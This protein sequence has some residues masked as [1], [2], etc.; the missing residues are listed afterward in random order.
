MTN[1]EQQSP[2]A[3]RTRLDKVRAH[4]DTLGLKN[5]ANIVHNPSYDALFSA[6]TN[7]ALSGFEKGTVTDSGAVNVD[8]GIYTGRSPKDKFIVKDELTKD[9][10]W[11]RTADN[12]NDNKPISIETWEALKSI[13]QQQLS[14]SDLFVVDAICGANANTALKVR[15]V[16]QVAWQAHFV[17]NMFIRPTEEQL[18]NFEPDFVVMNASKAKDP[19]FRKHQTNSETFVAFNLTEKIQLIGGTWYGGEMKKGMFSMMNYFLPLQGIASMHCSANVCKDNNTAIFFGL[20][21]TGKTTLSADPNRALIG[22]DEHGWDDDGVFNFEGGCYAKT[23]DLDPDKEPEIYHAIKRNALLENVVIKGNVPDYS[24]NQKTE[25]TRVSYP[26]EHIENRVLGVCKAGHAK[27]VIFLTADAF[28]VFPPVSRLTSEQAK[29]HYLSG[30]TAKLAGTER[31]VTHPTPTFSSCFGQAFLSLHP[32]Q[33]A[34]VLEQRM[35][36]AGAS[37]YLVNTGWN[38]TGKRISLAATR[39]IINAIL[40]GEVEESEC[41]ILPYFNLAFPTTLSGVDSDIL[42]PR[43]TYANPAEWDEEAKKLAQLFIDN[44]SKF[45]DNQEGKALTLAGPHL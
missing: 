11:W 31:G 1:N 17:K 26:I 13:S 6:E 3:N 21:G 42:D 23:I 36:T 39:A 28:G 15:F 9:T 20:S 2:I 40:D 10:V 32:T 5:I 29:Y 37:A 33:Y 44:F 34:H 24:D 22:D 12:N 43:K 41:E 14:D 4:L 38:G 18:D 19:E 7:D 35:T 27:K 25:N 16:M 8:T 30:F 45:T